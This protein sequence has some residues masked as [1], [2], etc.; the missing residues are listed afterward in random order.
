[1]RSLPVEGKFPYLS[2]AYTGHVLHKTR[3]YPFILRFE[4]A[5][6]FVRRKHNSLYLLSKTFA[7]Y[8]KRVLFSLV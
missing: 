8:L 1:M 4:Q 7:N 2:P 5:S 6:A 3:T